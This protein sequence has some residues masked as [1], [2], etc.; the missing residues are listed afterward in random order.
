MNRYI[1][2]VTLNRNQNSPHAQKGIVPC[3]G[4]GPRH[5]P[6]N[7][8]TAIDDTTTVLTYS[9]SMNIANAMPEYSV[10]NPATSSDSASERSNGGRFTSAS[11]Q[12]RKIANAGNCGI[13]YQTAACASTIAEV[14]RCPANISRATSDSPI[15]T[16]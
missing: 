12:I 14:R 6:R 7:S 10:W 4:A 5:P 11:A 13:A 1:T 16:S 2:Q 3:H 9:P 8:V 15:A